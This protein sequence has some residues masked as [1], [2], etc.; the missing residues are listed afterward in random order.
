[1]VY[2]NAFLKLPIHV[3]CTSILVLIW[4]VFVKLFLIYMYIL[5]VQPVSTKSTMKQKKVKRLLI[6]VN[7]ILLGDTRIPTTIYQYNS[8][9][10]YA[11]FSYHGLYIQFQLFL[12][13]F[14]FIPLPISWTSKAVLVKPFSFVIIYFLALVAFTWYSGVQHQST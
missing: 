9:C 13:L 3:N 6:A 5:F 1:M 8:T 7:T 14:C 11:V 2:W 4:S 12:F 10:E